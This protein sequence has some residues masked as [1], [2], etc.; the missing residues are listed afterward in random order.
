VSVRILEL[1]E[2]HLW[3]MILPGESF[4]LGLG[5]ISHT[6]IE[7]SLGHFWWRPRASSL[8]GK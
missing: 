6:L 1:P 2:N 7:Q 8:A 3:E 4:Q 5:Y